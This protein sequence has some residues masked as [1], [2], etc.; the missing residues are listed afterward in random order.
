MSVGEFKKKDYLANID[1]K[2][3]NIFKMNDSKDDQSLKVIGLTELQNDDNKSDEGGVSSR[4]SQ[5]NALI[6]A[7]KSNELSVGQSTSRSGVRR[8]K[9]ERNKFSE[10]YL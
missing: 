6:T 1:N 8:R 9:N 7:R 2:Y 3:K 5:I 4:L 10:V